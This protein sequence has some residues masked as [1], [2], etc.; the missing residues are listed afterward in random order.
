MKRLLVLIPNFWLVLCLSGCHESEVA[1]LP[2]LLEVWYYHPV[3]LKDGGVYSDWWIDL[4][5]VEELD[6]G[7]LVTGKRVNYWNANGTLGDPRPRILF[8]E[9]N[10]FK[11]RTEFYTGLQAYITRFDI[12]NL[13]EIV[14]EKR[15]PTASDLRAVIGRCQKALSDPRLRFDQAVRARVKELLDDQGIPQLKKP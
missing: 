11:N 4:E 6:D 2:A 5:R 12:S 7:L 14:K 13:H 1:K 8:P 15:H 10:N 9:E 3:F